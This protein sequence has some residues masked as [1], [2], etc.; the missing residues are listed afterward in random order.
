MKKVLE[1]DETSVLRR[2]KQRLAMDTQLQRDWW[3]NWGFLVPT[4]G[5]DEN[6][7]CRGYVEKDRLQ[8][9]LE[10]HKEP[11]SK[12]SRAVLSSHGI[13]WSANLELFGV[14]QHKRLVIDEDLSVNRKPWRIMKPISIQK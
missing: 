11:K 3:L 10:R 14:G 7:V 5:P 1:S 4:S 6:E 12:Y 2:L 13:G 9:I 8:C